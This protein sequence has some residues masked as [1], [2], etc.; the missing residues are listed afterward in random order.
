MASVLDDDPD[1]PPVPPDPPPPP[2]P[3]ATVEELVAHGWAVIE[4]KKAFRPR[5]EFLQQRSL[6]HLEA[7]KRS[8]GQA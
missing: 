3:E 7:L 4:W 2:G 1:I 6:R 5:T 8:I